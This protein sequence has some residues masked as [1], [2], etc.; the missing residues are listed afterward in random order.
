[1]LLQLAQICHLIIPNLWLYHLELMVTIVTKFS[2]WI[3]S[4]ILIF[5][6]EIKSHMLTRQ[7]ILI[8]IQFPHGKRINYYNR[9]IYKSPVVWRFLFF[10][11][12][13]FV[14]FVC[15]CVLKKTQLIIHLDTIHTSF[16]LAALYI[17][18]ILYSF[19][20]RNLSFSINKYHYVLGFVYKLARRSEW[21]SLWT[22]R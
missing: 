13:C 2:P 1:L 9:F 11:V 18:L 19:N 22:M 10:R 4:N 20:F 8:M 15:V 5:H 17:R 16:R 7:H 12:L 21:G 14:F 3:L 6:N